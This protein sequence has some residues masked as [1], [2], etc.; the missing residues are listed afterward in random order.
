LRRSRWEI[1][2]E[3]LEKAKRGEGITNLMLKC[4][5]SYLQIKSYVSVLLSKGM[6]KTVG[7]KS[8]RETYKTTEKG[9][10]FLSKIEDMIKFWEGGS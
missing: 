8:A 1:Y 3:I 2:A 5:M 7:S 6:L 4:R 9:R 10:V